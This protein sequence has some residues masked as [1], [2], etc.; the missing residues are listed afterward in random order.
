MKRNSS[1]KRWAIMIGVVL[2]IVVVVGGIYGYNTYQM[3]QGFK[4]MGVPKQT[5][6]TAKV[7]ALEWR[8]LLNAV[9]TVRAARGAD[10]SAEVSGIVDDIRFQSGQTVQGKTLLLALRSADEAAQLNSLKSTAE[11][12][13]ITYTRDQAQYQAQAISKAQLENAE[14]SLKS[15][16]AQVAQQSALLAKK[17]IYAPFAGTLG[18]R[19]VDLGQFLQAGSK[20]VTLQAL[21]P[22]YI[23]FYLPQQALSLLADGQTVN[24]GADAYPGLSFKGEISAID[25][26]VDTDTR[27]VQIRATLKN[28]GHK[29]LP[30]MYANISIEVGKTASYLTVPQNAVTF[31]PYGETVFVV[32]TA[33]EVKAEQEAKARAEGTAVVADKKAAETPPAAAAPADDQQKV[34]RQVFVTVG[35]A[36]GDQIAILKGLK[37]GDEVVTSGQ[38]KLKNGTPIEINNKVL[39]LD[40]PDPKPVDE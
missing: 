36:R 28:P 27:N 8:P 40:N 29:L 15:A 13:E 23:D 32:A 3:I 7:S 21:D 12:A 2:L 1:L 34:A 35:P 10:L 30:G 20:I 26:K 19:A 22:V 18:I 37:A 17:F 4:A 5:I 39:P 16:R 25:P 38:L 14:A 24:A 6:S 33:G 9:G 31:N 11:L